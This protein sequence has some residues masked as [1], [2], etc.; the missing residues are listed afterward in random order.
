[1]SLKAVL[2]AI[3]L[4]DSATVTGGEVAAVLRA[5]GLTDVEVKPFSGERGRTDFLRVRVPGVR[6]RAIGGEAP[7]LGV[8]GRLGGIGAR[9]EKIGLVSDGDGAVTVVALA[10]K[11]AWMRAKDDH[12]AGDVVIATHLCPHA[13]TMVQ[14]VVTMMSSPVDM[15]TLNREE[16][17]PE[18]A[19][20]LSVDTTRGNRA[21]NHRGIAISPTVKAG[22]I[23][24][25]SEDLITILQHVTGR[26]AVVVPLTMQDITPYGN[27][28]YHLNS[29]VQPSTA[30]DAPV[31]GVA[32]TAELPVPGSATGASQ[33]TDIDLAVRFC[34]EVAKA[35]G[36]GECRFYDR[37]EWE[38][39]QRRYGPMTHLQTLGR[40]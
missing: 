32:L 15:T 7:T 36:Q 22:W 14:P 11:L 10:L 26:A 20:L 16:V 13:P 8:I 19:A 35:F 21:L 4:L 5:A 3:E 28:L 33:A 9:P 25:V 38:T 30:T 40:G 39:I 24:R 18:M 31:V 6:G 17:Q 1:M 27:G 2:E 23:L 29:I 34:L 12:L 37:A